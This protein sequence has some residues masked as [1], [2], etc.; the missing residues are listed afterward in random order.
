M[1]SGL[2]GIKSWGSILQTPLVNGTIYLLKAINAVLVFL[3]IRGP[4]EH[5]QVP[6]IKLHKEL[7]RCTTEPSVTIP[8]SS[9]ISTSSSEIQLGRHQLWTLELEASQA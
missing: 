8:V 5:A 7:L 9:G 2:H 6:S 3:L 1:T 4:N